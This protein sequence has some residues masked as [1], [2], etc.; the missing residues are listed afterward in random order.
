MNVY[1]KQL[2]EAIK[3]NICTKEYI[4]CGKKIILESVTDLDF[5]VEAVSDETFN[6]DERL[7]YWAH[8]WPSS[9][10]LAE[11]LLEQGERLK[12]KEI[13]E[14]GCGL[15]LAGIAAALV[16][17]KVLFTDYEEIALTFTRKNYALN[18]QES[19]DV[20]VLDWR[21][22]TMDKKF[23]IILA[24]DVIYEKRFFKPLVKTLERIL[25][26]GGLALITEPKRPLAKNFFAML[27]TKSYNHLI[28]PLATRYDGS[29][30]EI[31][32]HFVWKR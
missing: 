29:A 5:V 23:D 7:P 26:K 21:Q 25:F 28:Q 15:G 1:S 3:D 27:D 22:N 18:L 20:K 4:L 8:L 12:G 16:G 2:T 24:A 19:P 14:L 9:V 31:E 30:H 6:Q 17:A 32:L 10:A 11:Y 13:I